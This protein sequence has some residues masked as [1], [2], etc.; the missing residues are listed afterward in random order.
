MMEFIE[1]TVHIA[2]FMML[3]VAIVLAAIEIFDRLTGA[4]AKRQAELERLEE[5]E[6]L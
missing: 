4:D 2:L 3:M 6:D 5:M 1:N